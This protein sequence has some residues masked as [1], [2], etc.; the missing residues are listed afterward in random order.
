MSSAMH[1]RHSQIQDNLTQREILFKK[2]VF[3]GLSITLFVPILYLSGGIFATSFAFFIASIFAYFN[4]VK[5]KNINVPFI[6]R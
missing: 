1:S 4:Y 3:Y 5:I 6:K 2:D